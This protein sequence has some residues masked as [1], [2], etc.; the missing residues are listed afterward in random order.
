MEKKTR[1][2]KKRAD[3]EES[4]KGCRTVQTGGIGRQNIGVVQT[5]RGKTY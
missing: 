2:V 1:K 4:G 5:I 3:E